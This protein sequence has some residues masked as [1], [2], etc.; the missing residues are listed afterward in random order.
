MHTRPGVCR[1][2][3]RGGGDN[4]KAMAAPYS[5]Q[6]QSF[7]DI[8]GDSVSLAKLQA[9][10][11]PFLGGLSFLDIGCNE[12]FFCG[13]AQ[14]AKAR[15]VVGLDASQLYIERARQRYPDIEFLHQSW[16][17]LPQGPFDLILLAS[18]LHYA[19]DQADLI[20]RAVDRLAPSGTLVLELGVA[21]GSHA[22]WVEVNRGADKRLFATWAQLQQTLAPYAWKLIGN[23]VTQKG[24]PI[25][26]S[27][28]HI[29]R[30][31]PIAY[32][33]Q[34]PPG[35]G[36]TTLTVTL[37]KPAGVE[38]VSSDGCLMAVASGSIACDPALKQAVSA[39]CT[40]D[41]LDKTLLAVL[42]AGLLTQWLDLMLG[43]TSGGSVA[44][45]AWIPTEFRPKAI[46]HLRAKGYLPVALS[47]EKPSVQLQ[48][49]GQVKDMA[50]SYFAYL[51]TQHHGAV[52]GQPGAAHAPSA[53]QVPAI[54]PS[55]TTFAPQARMP[56]KG[57]LGVL[58]QLGINSERLELFG[59]AVHEDGHMPNVLEVRIGTHRHLE[60]AFDRRKYPELQV[61]L[62]L[63]HAMYGFRFSMPVP[64][65]VH[66]RDI[67]QL[68]EV[69]GG[70]SEQ[71]LHGPFH[72]EAVRQDAAARAAAAQR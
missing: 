26:R 69:Y 56:F 71:A 47:W 64:P 63:P 37:F 25:P 60:T 53:G 48:A 45:D 19:S 40:P 46:Q 57:T 39:G 66:L 50:E 58:T 9:L 16:D 35:F 6:Y 59:W 11:L 33:L 8:P 44:L 27:T 17:E 1:G 54:A 7:P 61:R 28:L 65:G 70:A 68:L 22:A 24:D 51:S 30:R 52:V 32:L 36:K 15:R 3:A 21:P 5:P 55:G 41:A 20:R 43:Q 29:N 13:Y 72:S 38:V 31:L 10:R 42:Q 67:P 49:R 4:H 18:S 62:K 23:S 2:V 34:E 14:F 12:G